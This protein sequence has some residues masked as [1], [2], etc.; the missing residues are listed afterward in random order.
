MLRLIMALT[1]ILVLV[2]T[3]GCATTGD[4]DKT[5]KGGAIGTVAGAAL[6]AALGAA[7]GDPAKGAWIGAAVGAAAGTTTGVTLDAQEEK[8]RQLGIETKRLSDRQ[9]L[10]QLT[11]NDLRFDFDKATIRP[12]DQARLQQ[13]ARVLRDYPEHRLIV[14]GHTDS[15]GSDAYND[16]LSQRRAQS[17]STFLIHAGVPPAS[18][19]GLRGYGETQPIAPNTTP[20][21]RA[22]NRRVELTITAP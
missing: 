18:F 8:L 13:V 4:G 3:S 12:G 20:D 9:L 16:E 15:I 1:L 10:V 19:V 11:G 22:Q 17:V 5:L 2:M 21:G 7:A 6:G 14:A